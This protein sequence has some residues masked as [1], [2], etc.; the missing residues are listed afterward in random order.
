[1]ISKTVEVIN[2]QGMHMRPAGILAKAAASY[3]DCDITLNA[4]EKNVNAK[5]LMQ[6]MSAGIKCGNQVLITCNGRDEQQ[7]LD[8]IIRLFQDGFGE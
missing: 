3:K 5:A 1:M 4:N 6:I 8:E 2:S 7:A